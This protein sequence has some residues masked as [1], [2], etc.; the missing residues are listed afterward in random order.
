MGVWGPS[1]N[2][3]CWLTDVKGRVSA[4]PGLEWRGVENVFPCT[5]LILILMKAS[6]YLIRVPTSLPLVTL[7]L[8]R[9]EGKNEKVG[10]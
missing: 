6:R 4:G 9:E 2:D 1:R 3:R 8:S 7:V 10:K 5:E